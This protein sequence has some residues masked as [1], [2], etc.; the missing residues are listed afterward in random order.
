LK[1]KDWLTN[2]QDDRNGPLEKEVVALPLTH[3]ELLVVMRNLGVAHESQC[4]DVTEKQT[5]GSIRER[6]ARF[7]ERQGAWWDMPR[8]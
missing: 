7:A 4:T 6:I 8:H 5:I 3:R 2:K 1:L